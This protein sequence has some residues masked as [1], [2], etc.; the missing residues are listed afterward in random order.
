MSDTL[1]DIELSSI[2][3]MTKNSYQLPLV[4]KLSQNKLNEQV[5]VFLFLFLK[6][7]VS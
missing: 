3:V 1:T 5:S 6:K 2:D 4:S 7:C